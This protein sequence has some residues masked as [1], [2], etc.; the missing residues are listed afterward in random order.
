MNS[1]PYI[2]YDKTESQISEL[3]INYSQTAPPCASLDPKN[4]KKL[5]REFKYLRQ[6][7]QSIHQNLK[8]LEESL[9]ITGLYNNFHPLTI[10]LD[11]FQETLEVCDQFVDLQSKI[12]A[13]ISEVKEA[14]RAL[15]KQIL[16]YNLPR[17]EEGLDHFLDRCDLIADKLDELDS[18]G[19]QIKELEKP[20]EE[21]IIFIEQF[22]ELLDERTEALTPKK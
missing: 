13:E 7:C 20:Y 22:R 11:N 8:V 18:R 17:F 2:L 10:R 3:T 5:K 21:W 1:E 12:E 4:V 14:I 19:H 6:A 16:P 15:A 9:D